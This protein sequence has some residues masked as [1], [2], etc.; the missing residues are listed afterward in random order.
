VLLGHPERSEAKSK[1][2][3]ALPLS[4]RGGIPRLS[5]GM[6]ANEAFCLLT[7]ALLRVKLLERPYQIPR[8]GPDPIENTLGNRF[9]R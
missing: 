7:R 5:L 4:F 2:P 1:D 6:T 8:Q 3:D 9:R